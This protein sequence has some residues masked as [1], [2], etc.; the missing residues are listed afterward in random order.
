VGNLLNDIKSEGSRMGK[1][2][3][4]LEILEELSD[5]DREDLLAALDDHSIPASNIREAMKKRGHKLNVDVIARYRRG[6]LVTNIH[7][8]L[9]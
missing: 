3:R 1:K 7:E 5:E 4:I 8:S 9:G 2:S 6:E